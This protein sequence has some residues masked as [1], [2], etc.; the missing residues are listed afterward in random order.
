MTS[1]CH[2][3]IVMRRYAQVG[4]FAASFHTTKRAQ[5]GPAFKDRVNSTSSATDQNPSRRPESASLLSVKEN[6]A[7]SQD[8]LQ[9][10]ASQNESCS[11][12]DTSNTHGRP[13]VEQRVAASPPARSGPL[14]HSV[15]IQS[16]LITAD[17][18]VNVID[19]ILRE[20]GLPVPT[21]VEQRLASMSPP[22]LPSN[23]T[24]VNLPAFQAP[25]SAVELH[26]ISRS[27]EAVRCHMERCVQR[28]SY[29][30]AQQAK[31][32]LDRLQNLVQQVITCILWHACSG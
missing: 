11:T 17:T 12:T 1:Y 21:P 20:L 23:A 27:V 14:I 4:L 8:V 29:G 22:P 19:H 32:S 28:Q 25:P 13:A 15:S 7:A 6:V 9:K 10:S 16:E 2:R 18:R 24:G 30:L 26:S 3:S 5:P 31:E